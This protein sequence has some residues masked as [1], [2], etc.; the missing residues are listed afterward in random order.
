[1]V[2]ERSLTAKYEEELQY[3]SDTR[4]DLEEA[5]YKKVENLESEYA[6]KKEN[7]EAM[8]QKHIEEVVRLREEAETVKLQEQEQKWKKKME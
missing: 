5:Y 1:M 8:K 6:K 3:M 4:V 2:Q 7:F